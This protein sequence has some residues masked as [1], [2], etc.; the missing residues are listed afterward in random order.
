MKGAIK[1]IHDEL[2]KE[3][4][5]ILAFFLNLKFKFVS[6]GIFFLRFKFLVKIEYREYCNCTQQL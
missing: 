6:D 3:Q 4:I 5:E 2:I 1:K